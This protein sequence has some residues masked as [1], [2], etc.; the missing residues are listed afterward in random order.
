MKPIATGICILLI[1]YLVLTPTP[2]E[3]PRV[4]LFEGADKVVHAC[5]MAGLMLCVAFDRLRA[6]LPLSPRSMLLA[7]LWVMA[8]GILT[9]QLQQASATPRTAD[10][11]DALADWTGTILATAAILLRSRRIA[12]ADSR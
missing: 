6:R 7:A 1:L 2:P 8:F 10:P 3:A 12:A 11:L 5:M 9:E 4:M